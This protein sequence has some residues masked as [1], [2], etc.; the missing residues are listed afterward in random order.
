MSR[1][2]R[3]NDYSWHWLGVGMNITTTFL[4]Y[5]VTFTLLPGW[6]INANGQVYYEVNS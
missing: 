3:Y 5:T 1:Y 4:R 6:Y 2:G